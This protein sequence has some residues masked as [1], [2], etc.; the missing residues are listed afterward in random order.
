MKKSI[1]LSFL[2]LSSV[3]FSGSEAPKIGSVVFFDYS[4][5][6]TSDADNDAGFGLK[7]VYFTVSNKLADNLSFKLQTDVN[8]KESPKNVYLKNAKVD[9]KTNAGKFTIGLQGMNVFSIQEKTW[10]YRF[11]DKS[12]MD[13]K[14]FSSSADMGIGYATKFADKFRFSILYTNGV[15]YKKS[16]DDSH[17]KI[18]MQAYMGQPK[19]SSKDGLNVGGVFTFEPYDFES[20]S[21]SEITTS[22]KSVTV[23]GLFGGY[24]S[25]VIRAGAEFNLLNDSGLDVDEQIFSAYAN[26]KLSKT[27]QVY[28]RIDM[29]DPDTD[30]DDDSENYFIIGCEFQPAS[31]L[32]IA[33]NLRM[34]SPESGDSETVIYLNFQFKL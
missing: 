10:G 9:W 5:D 7:R 18:S 12:A 27:L 2:F 13:R 16:E 1:I 28:G 25:G 26:Y 17:K 21:G 23:M 15:G 31:G 11:I 30:Y 14:K 32:Y 20:G 22:E 6:T 33:P 3:L 8:Y 19:L 34:T 4:Y 24:A 29:Y